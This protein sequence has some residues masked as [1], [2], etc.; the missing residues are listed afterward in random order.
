MSLRVTYRR[1]AIALVNHFP[2]FNDE[3]FNDKVNY[4]IK[5]MER[6]PRHQQLAI[7]T[8]YIF[9]AKSPDVDREDC[10]QDFYLAVHKAMPKD[11]ALAYFVAKC[12]WINMLQKRDTRKKILNGGFLSLSKPLVVMLGGNREVIAGLSEVI[13]DEN[14]FIN[15]IESKVDAERALQAL[16]D[17]TPMGG[18]IGLGGSGWDGS[19]SAE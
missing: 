10:F 12:T 4:Y 19:Y 16:L 5:A 1:I 13:S 2:V 15:S 8:A 6:L 11:D 3:D 7:K 14:S 9:A 17:C 18:Q